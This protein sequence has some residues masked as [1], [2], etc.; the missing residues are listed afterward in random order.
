MSDRAGVP[1]WVKVGG[2]EYNIHSDPD[3]SA[4]TSDDGSRGVTFHE[5]QRIHIDSTLGADVFRETLIHECIHAAWDVVGLTKAG[6]VAQHEEQ[7]IK[8]LSPTITALI[9]EN[10][11][12]VRFITERG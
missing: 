11:Q 5:R 4:L 6:D 10:P 7:I 12:L 9:R 2:R 8:A 1:V 3:T